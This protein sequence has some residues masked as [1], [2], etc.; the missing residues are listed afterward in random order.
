M[1]EDFAY[2]TFG[3]SANA[4]QDEAATIRENLGTA[5][6]T[7]CTTVPRLGSKLSLFSGTHGQR[8]DGLTNAEEDSRNCSST[9]TDGDGI[10]IGTKSTVTI[11]TPD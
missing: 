8:S 3:N 6:E 10:S 4:E 11:L 7:D 1:N 2:N 9:H 5:D